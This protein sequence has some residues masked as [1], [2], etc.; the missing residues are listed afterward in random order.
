MTRAH[1]PTTSGRRSDADPGEAWYAHR[2]A[3]LARRRT[4][5]YTEYN[6]RTANNSRRAPAHVRGVG[7]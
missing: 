4:L 2:S 5:G 6:G 3:L 1:R 7:L